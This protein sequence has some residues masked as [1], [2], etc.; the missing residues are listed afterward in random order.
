M[1]LMLAMTNNILGP[2]TRTILGYMIQREVV[3]WVVIDVVSHV[4]M[5]K[6]ASFCILGPVIEV[7]IFEDIIALYQKRLFVPDISNTTKWPSILLLAG[8][9][10]VFFSSSGTVTRGDSCGCNC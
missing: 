8:I 5:T 2:G 1:S 3:V 10:A 7:R 6:K 9:T 4:E